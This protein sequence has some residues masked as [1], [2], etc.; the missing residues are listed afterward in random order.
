MSRESYRLRSKHVPTFQLGASP[1]SINLRK[2]TN[3]A[4][5]TFLC[6]VRNNT[7]HA[8]SRNPLILIYVEFLFLSDLALPNALNCAG[9]SPPFD[10]RKPRDPDFEMCSDSN[11]WIRIKPGYIPSAHVDKLFW[12]MCRHSF[13]TKKE[14]KRPREAWHFLVNYRFCCPLPC[15]SFCRVW[16]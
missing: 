7:R 13:P 2:E 12:L 10:L 9:A 6:F 4:S 14:T 8:K 15:T 1:S 11:A 3:S 5:E 16:H